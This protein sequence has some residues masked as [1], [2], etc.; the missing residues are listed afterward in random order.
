M[1]LIC[2]PNC[3]LFWSSPVIPKKRYCKNSAFLMGTILMLL[4][5][6]NF[7]G[8][9]CKKLVFKSLNVKEQK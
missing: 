3:I 7:V 6:V 8:S 2:A 5:I 4:F 9:T 1:L